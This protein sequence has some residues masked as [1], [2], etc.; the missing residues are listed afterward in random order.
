ML[1]ILDG[2]LIG[3][4]DGRKLGE[5]GSDGDGRFIVGDLS[6]VGNIIGDRVPRLSSNILL[7]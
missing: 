7:S 2:R 1:G 4:D 3:R 5:L 6:Y